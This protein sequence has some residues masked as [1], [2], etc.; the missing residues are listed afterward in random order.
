MPEME[1]ATQSSDDNGHFETSTDHVET[2]SQKERLYRH[3]TI[4]TTITGVDHTTYNKVKTQTQTD[5]QFEIDPFLSF[6]PL[7]PITL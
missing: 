5:V 6:T 1:K 3:D 7:K 4:R 2:G